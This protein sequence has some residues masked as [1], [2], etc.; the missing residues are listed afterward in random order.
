MAVTEG[1]RFTPR[2]A[3]VASFVGRLFLV[4]AACIGAGD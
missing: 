3:W 2:P 4:S 1:A